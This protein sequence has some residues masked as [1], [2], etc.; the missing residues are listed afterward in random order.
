MDRQKVRTLRYTE[1][2]ESNNS[3]TFCQSTQAR[4]NHLYLVI[5]QILT[6]GA[7]D[8]PGDCTTGNCE[9][10]TCGAAALLTNETSV[11][12]LSALNKPLFK[13]LAKSEYYNTGW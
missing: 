5:M 13:T 7:C 3:S 10:V 1:T 6:W 4:S 9:G 12:N 2:R 8:E 11:C